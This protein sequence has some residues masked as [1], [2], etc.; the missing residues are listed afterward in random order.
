MLH[1]EWF[2]GD[3]FARKE[4]FCANVSICATAKIIFCGTIFNGIVFMFEVHLQ[5][6][7]RIISPIQCLINIE[8]MLAFLH[9]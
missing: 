4:L 2:A 9:R 7:N 1:L 5:Q 3:Y 6:K 8:L